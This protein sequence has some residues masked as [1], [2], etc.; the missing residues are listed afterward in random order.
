MLKYLRI[1]QQLT[2]LN[3]SEF[4]PR[5]LAEVAHSFGARKS[6]WCDFFPFPCEGSKTHNHQGMRHGPSPWYWPFLRMDLYVT[7]SSYSYAKTK[8]THV[9]QMHS[10]F[11]NSFMPCAPRTHLVNNILSQEQPSLLGLV[12][13][14][15]E[16]V[17]TLFLP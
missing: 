8:V 12:V 14:M 16:A 6:L 15:A 17:A 4:G 9:N 10:I 3:N 2:N 1:V 13:D 5:R 11:Q 7:C